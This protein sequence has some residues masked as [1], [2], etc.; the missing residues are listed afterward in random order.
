MTRCSVLPG[1]LGAP[2][3]I[4]CRKSFL[5]WH[6]PARR[7]NVSAPGRDL[8]PPAAEMLVMTKRIHTTTIAAAAIA[9]AAITAPAKASASI[10]DKIFGPKAVDFTFSLECRTLESNWNQT[11]HLSEY[12]AV[13]QFEQDHSVTPYV[14][15]ADDGVESYYPQGRIAFNHGE[16]DGTSLPAVAGM[17]IVK[18][19]P[20]GITLQGK[21]DIGSHLITTGTGALRARGRSYRN[22]HW[23][24][25]ARRRR[26]LP[27]TDRPCR[28]A[29]GV[30][31]IPPL[32]ADRP[33]CGG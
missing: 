9:L 2:G 31:R 32:A 18:V 21:S 30:R 16:P 13:S 20:E 4:R 22:V 15:G 27:R 3:E 1:S 7:P 33:S 23:R 12:D 5:R 14:N 17:Y 26:R 25:C 24:A 28:W 11:I 19:T 6:W 29:G 8:P 10:L